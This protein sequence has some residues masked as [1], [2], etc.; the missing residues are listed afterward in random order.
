MTEASS[1]LEWCGPVTGH[2]E[3]YAFICC[4]VSLWTRDYQKRKKNISSPNT[5]FADQKTEHAPRASVAQKWLSRQLVAEILTVASTAVSSN[6]PPNCRG[7]W[8]LSLQSLL[9]VQHVT[10]EGFH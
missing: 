8:N 5:G 4:L 6:C 7:K 10:E 1:S 9:K 3:I 2:Q